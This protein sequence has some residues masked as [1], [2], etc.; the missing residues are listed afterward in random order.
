MLTVP[1]SDVSVCD[2]ARIALI[3]FAGSLASEASACAEETAL[4]EVGLEDGAFAPNSFRRSAVETPPNEPSE[5]IMTRLSQIIS[6]S[7][8]HD[9]RIIGR[10]TWSVIFVIVE[11]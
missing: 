9:R 8:T 4:A 6:Q 10:E 1:P 7:I 3:A 11:P 5:E 2:C